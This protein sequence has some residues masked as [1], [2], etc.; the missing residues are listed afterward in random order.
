MMRFAILNETNVV[1]NVAV[2][3]TALDANWVASN[4]AEIG[5]TYAGG[6]FT[7]PEP[8][9]N[10]QWA[11]VR[12]ERN[13]KL[14]RC[15]WTQL[16]DAPADTAAWATYRQELRDITTQDDPFNIAWPSEPEF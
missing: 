5:D 10:A 9:T 12:A 4:T 3:D 14:A 15:D 6:V 7:T 11:V 1:V 8:N 13:T 2:G 16:P